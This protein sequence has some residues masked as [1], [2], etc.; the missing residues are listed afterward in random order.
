MGAALVEDAAL[1]IADVAVL[2]TADS[3]FV[4]A[5][6]S[7]KRV[8]Q[9]LSLILAMPPGNAKPNKR[10]RNVG[11]FSINETALRRAQLP[12]EVKD[13]VDGTVYQRPEKWM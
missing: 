4:P 1:G 13:P 5:V 12:Q 6:A 8:S 7:A 9:G 10:F 3:D 11:Y 2:V